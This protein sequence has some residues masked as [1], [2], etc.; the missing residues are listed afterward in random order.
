VKKAALWRVSV[1]TNAEAEEAVLAFLEAFFGQNPCS[2]TDFETGSVT[3]M[4]F[5]KRPPKCAKMAHIMEEVGL[6]CVPK[7][8]TLTRVRKEDWAESW[9]RHFKPFTIGKAL[10]V[11]PSW[12]RRKPRPRQRAVV[13]D[14]GLSFGTG[15]HPTTRFCLEQLAGARNPALRQSFLDVGT[16]SGIL[17]VAAAKLG[18]AP[19]RAF[20]FDP[21]AVRV[22]KENAQKNRVRIAIKRGDITKTSVGPTKYD[23]VCAN[24]TA[25][26]LE[27]CAGKLKQFVKTAGLLVLAGI[28]RTQIEPLRAIFE[29][30]GF[31]AV[32]QHAEK[33]W[34]SFALARRRGME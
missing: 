22:A 14:P 8:L 25:D 30:H 16:G 26:L 27:R 7:C 3:C 24:L 32:A 11:K 12:S 19:V 20:D 21:A 9:K 1:E 13:I 28:L 2:Y 29:E 5:V 4:V 15:Q 34:Q 33:E 23:V 31:R 6:K 10:L 17:A 18:Y